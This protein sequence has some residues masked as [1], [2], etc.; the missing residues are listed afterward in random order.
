MSEYYYKL[1][2][3]EAERLCEELNIKLPP[4]RKE[5]GM[6]ENEFIVDIHKQRVWLNK[7]KS[8]AIQP[9]HYYDGITGQFSHEIVSLT[10]QSHFSQFV[11]KHNVPVRVFTY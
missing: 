1:T 4:T 10:T 2:P 9:C 11:N 5:L 8:I 7:A 3:E 6:E